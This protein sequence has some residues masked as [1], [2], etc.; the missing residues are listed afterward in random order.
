MSNY[1]KTYSGIVIEGQKRG[2]KLG[3]PTANIPLSDGSLSG[4]Y[5]GLVILEGKKYKA[6]L[7]ADQKRRVFEAYILDFSGDIYGKEIHIS[8]HS[9]LR[10]A[11]IFSDDAELKTVIASDVRGVVEFFRK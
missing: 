5:A 1:P 7:F 4:V 2:R 8:I 10:D 6:A 11:F 9:K 3:F